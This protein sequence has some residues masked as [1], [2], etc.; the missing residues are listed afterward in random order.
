MQPSDKRPAL[1]AVADS[2]TGMFTAWFPRNPAT[3]PVQPAS[4]SASGLHM[5]VRRRLLSQVVVLEVAGQLRDVIE[6]LN[7]AV[8]VTLADGP[9]GVVCDLSAVVEGA[10]PLAVE[11]LAGVGRH[12]RDWPGIPV[13]VACPDLQVRQAL[14]AHPLGGHLIVTASLF[15]AVCAVLATPALTVEW[16]HLAPHPTAIRAS[17]DFVTRTLLDWRLDRAIRFARPVISELVM[18]STVNAGTDL[19]LSVSWDLGALRLTVRDYSPGPPPQ[20]GPQ[21]P[22]DPAPGLHG[23]ALAV[24]AGLSRAFGVLPTADGGRVVWAVLDA[25]SQRQATLRG[26]AAPVPPS[27]RRS[28][29]ATT[30]KES[31]MS[32]TDQG[33]SANTANVIHPAEPRVPLSLGREHAWVQD[34]AATEDPPATDPRLLRPAPSAEPAPSE[35]PAPSAEPAASARV[36]PARNPHIRPF[37]DPCNYLG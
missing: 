1:S 11:V 4:C 25:P 5:P 10:E 30:Q 17:R 33:R 20:R 16:L 34:D 37:D 29:A 18:S 27:H 3:C 35:E 2:H 36:A 6:D 22:R 31:H 28:Q 26:V 13:A 9:R 7:H 23:R 24:V 14:G 8:Q 21:P 12:V 15:S 32:P 19:D